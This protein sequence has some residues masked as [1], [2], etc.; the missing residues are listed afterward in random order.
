[1]GTHM[2][3]LALADMRR[4][5]KAPAQRL[6]ARGHDV[7]LWPQAEDRITPAV[8]VQRQIRPVPQGAQDMCRAV[9]DEGQSR[10]DG[11][12]LSRDRPGRH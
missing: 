9:P 2:A 4:M 6:I 5:G 3:R 12:S 1:M 7:T 8:E 11:T 10:A